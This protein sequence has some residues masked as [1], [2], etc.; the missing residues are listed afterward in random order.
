MEPFPLAIVY[1]LKN[2][3]KKQQ[4]LAQLL[5]LQEIIHQCQQG[6]ALAWEH[7]VRG[8]QSRI[9]GL[10]YYF[11]K[12]SAEAEDVTQEVFIKV[13]KGLSGYRGNA[14]EF[15][16]WMLAIG[17]NS[18]LDRLRAR[19]RRDSVEMPEQEFE[20]Q[21]AVNDETV[22][23]SPE[24]LLGDQQIKNSRKQQIYAVLDQFNEQNR[25]I[26]LL[27]DIQGLK[28]ED[29]ANILNVSVGTVKSRSSRAR[30][31]LAKALSHLS[32]KSMRSCSNGM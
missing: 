10:A 30:I 19:K 22:E 5:D 31:K 21:P 3:I 6:N 24:S 23:N 7:L 20:S 17:R 28:N 11:L 2:T 1:P 8:Q 15:L 14:E 27:K 29:V 26:I 12:N 9:Y 18:C 13:Y 16:P 4:R 25:E 32:E